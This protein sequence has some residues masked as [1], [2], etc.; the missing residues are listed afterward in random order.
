MISERARG[1]VSV[2]VEADRLHVGRADSGRCAWRTCEREYEAWVPALDEALRS[3]PDRLRAVAADVL[4]ATT[5]GRTSDHVAAD[6]A[7]Y[8]RTRRQDTA[9][10]TGRARAWC[11]GYDRNAAILEGAAA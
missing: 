3:T 9:R 10:E 4:A 7:R 5:W 2:V 6:V 1:V 8:L 11:R